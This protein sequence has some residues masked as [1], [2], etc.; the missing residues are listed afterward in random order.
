MKGLPLLSATDGTAGAGSLP[1]GVARAQSAR[2]ERGQ[3]AAA[4]ACSAPEE[5]RLLAQGWARRFVGDTRM[6]EEATAL[7]SRLGYEVMT[8]PLDDARVDEPCAGCAVTLRSFR[9]LYT[10]RVED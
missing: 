10:R 6:T 3:G 7:Y 2:G 9:V 5:P 8:V 4:P 1:C